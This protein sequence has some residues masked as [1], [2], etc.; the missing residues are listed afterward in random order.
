MP[1]VDRGGF[2]NWIR[3][4]AHGQPL[5]ANQ[6]HD[7]HAPPWLYLFHQMMDPCVFVTL[8]VLYVAPHGDF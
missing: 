2:G 3:V 8:L 5:M 6:V 7:L 4:V 1:G